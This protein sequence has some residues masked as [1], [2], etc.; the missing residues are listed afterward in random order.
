MLLELM[1]PYNVRSCKKASQYLCV[2]ALIKPAKTSV[3][4]KCLALEV[5]QAFSQG[6]EKGGRRKHLE[7]KT[8]KPGGK[9]PIYPLSKHDML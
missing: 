6:A 8:G 2:Y 7:S 1:M 3:N 5:E 9:N 4:M